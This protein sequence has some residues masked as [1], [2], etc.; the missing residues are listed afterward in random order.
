MKRKG[1]VLGVGGKHQRLA[2]ILA[3]GASATQASGSGARVIPI[4]AK[5]G[6]LEG[7]AEV[8]VLLE[9]WGWAS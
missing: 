2:R 6:P 7:D 1:S 3:I 5:V 8:D 4:G 9:L